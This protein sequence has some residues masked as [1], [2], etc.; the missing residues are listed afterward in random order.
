MKIIEANYS[1]KF[2][3]APY[4]NED[5]G[6]RASLD[7]GEEPE[8]AILKLKAIAEQCWVKSNPQIQMGTDI[9]D[10]PQEQPVDKRVQAIIEDIKNCKA[11]Y[12]KNGFGIQVGLVAYE[13]ISSNHP[14]IKVEY[15]LKMLELQKN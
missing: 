9:R 12:E 6:F 5:I 2:P 3:Y 14:E 10:I 7:E 4:L 11:V 8:E 15:D 13:E 1:K